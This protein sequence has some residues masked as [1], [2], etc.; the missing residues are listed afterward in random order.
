MYA[1]SSRKVTKFYISHLYFKV[2]LCN[3]EEKFRRSRAIDR[4]SPA[5]S[6]RTEGG[7]P[8]ASRAITLLYRI[9]KDLARKSLNGKKPV[10]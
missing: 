10:L 6:H 9:V 3:G 1:D 5:K 7:E 4:L 2:I 8:Q